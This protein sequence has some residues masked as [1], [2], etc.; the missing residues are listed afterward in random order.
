MAWAQSAM[1]AMAWAPP[2]RA[3]TSS[4]TQLP[5][6]ACGV[7]IVGLNV[8]RGTSDEVPSVVRLRSLVFWCCFGM[9]FGKIADASSPA[10]AG[11]LRAALR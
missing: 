1:R 11:P 3:A 2:A 4:P 6:G 5:A 10:H 7:E 8:G 9:C